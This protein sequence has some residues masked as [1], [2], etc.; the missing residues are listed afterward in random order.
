M[1]AEEKKLRKTP[2]AGRKGGAV[3]PRIS[4]DDAVVY[5]RKLVSETHVSAQPADIIY[6][7]VVGAK[8]GR[9]NVRISALKQY[10]FLIGGIKSKYSASELA[11]KIVSAPQDELALLYR[12]S[13]L[14]PK[15]FKQLFDTFHGDTVSKAKLKQRVADLEVHPD[16]TERCV[17]L[18][19]SSMATAGLVT[20]E[21]D[22]TTHVA[23]T[24]DLA[25]PLATRTSANLELT[26][27]TDEESS[28]SEE[29]DTDRDTV[30]DVTTGG[31]S[32]TRP[33]GRI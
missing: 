15:I 21:G 18:Y 31:T 27:T 1:T 12:E 8:S 26:A 24:D 3:F 4:L 22:R 10:G 17:E 2:N 29:T 16:E 11:K 20:V 9:G 25:V 28:E 5:A 6:S 14:K 7:G 32:E 30:A 33:C 13:A 19:I 23:S